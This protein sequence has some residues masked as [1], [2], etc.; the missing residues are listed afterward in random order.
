MGTVTSFSKKIFEKGAV[1]RPEKPARLAVPEIRSLDI[2]FGPRYIEAPAADQALDHRLNVF[3]PRPDCRT[4]QFQIAASKPASKR[5]SQRGL[6]L[7]CAG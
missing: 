2:I 4:V 6:F 1:Y 5:Q 7:R 3:Y